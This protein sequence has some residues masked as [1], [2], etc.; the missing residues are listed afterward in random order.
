MPLAAVRAGDVAFL[1]SVSGAAVPGAETTIDH[2]RNEMTAGGMRQDMVERIAGLMALQYEYARTG[3]GWDEY[4]AMREELGAGRS[5]DT[6]P[7]TPDHPYWQ[8]VRRLY[9]SD[10]G[11]TLRRLRT[12]T[13]ALFGALDNNIL[14]EKNRAAW[15]AALKAGGNP[16]YTL[17]ILPRANHLQFEAKAGHNA[18]TLSLQRIVPDYFTTIR[19]WL[20]TRVEGFRGAR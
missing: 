12:P 19:D 20:A 11:P 5:P 10:P 9:F 2:A 14:P 13:L 15:E 7:D 16:D 17:R 1:I 18:E 8:V 4:L 3:Q 6:F